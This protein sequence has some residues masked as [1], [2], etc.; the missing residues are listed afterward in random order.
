MTDPLFDVATNLDDETVATD[1]A[2]YW[3]WL[4][5]D[6]VSPQQF[7]IAT[8]YFNPGGFAQ[9]SDQ[10]EQAEHVRLLLG[11]EPDAVADLNRLR[12]LSR[13]HPTQTQAAELRRRLTEHHREIAQDRDLVGFSRHDDALIRRMIDWLK[14][15]KVEVHRLESRFLHGKAYLAGQGPGVMVG[16]SN[17]TRAGLTRNVELNLAR[18]EPTPVTQVAD[19]FDRLW[20]ESVDYDLA[21]LYEQRFAEHDPYVVYLRMLWERYGT[22]LDQPEPSPHELP[23]TRFQK[24]GLYRAMGILHRHRG[25]LVADG[26]GLGKTYLAGELVR[27]A[28]YDRRQRVLVIAPAALRDGP[29]RQ[30]LHEHRIGGVDV[31]SYEQ[32]SADPKMGG[33]GRGWMSFE[34]HE[35]AMVVIDEAHAYRN[36]VAERAQVLRKL[37]SGTPPKE[38]VLLTAT[39]VN[40]SLWDLYHLLS[41]FVRNDGA[42]LDAGIPSLREQFKDA[43]A[44]DP[45]T[46]SP[47][48]LFDVLDAVAV[49]RTRGFVKRFYPGETIRR[50]D[51]EIP[52]TFPQPE[53]IRVDYDF[54]AVLPGFF[55]Q[56][57]HALGVD[58]SDDDNP[59]PHPDEFV[60]DDTARLKLAR[61]APSAFLLEDDPE[62]YELQA[63]G[64]LRSGLLKR[65]ESS[66]F[67]FANTCATMAGSHDL[68]LEALSHGWVLTGDALAAFAKTD[69]D[70]FDPAV[71]AGGGTREP[72][73]RYDVDKLRAAVETDRDLLRH[74]H[75]QAASIDHTADPKLAALVDALA[76]IAAQA[77]A[78]GGPEQTERDRRKVLVFSYY[79]DTV[80]WI[81]RHLRWATIHDDR[82]GVYTDRW[83]TVTGSGDKQSALFGFAPIAAQAPTETADQFDILVTTDVLAEG[84]NLQQARHIV[85]FDLPWNP[86]R[87]VQRHGRIDRIGS[88]HSR[89]FLRSFFPSTKLN[90]L[91]GLERAIT[92][93]LTQAAKSIGVEGTVI[94]GSGVNTELIFGKTDEQVRRLHA[95]DVSVLEEAEAAASLSG[96]E[97]RRELVE[98]LDDPALRGQILGL[99]WVAGTGKATEGPAGFV[100]CARVA[101]HDRPLYRWVPLDADGNV[102]GGRI[103]ADTLTCLARARCEPDTARTLP[104]GMQDAAYDAW[105]AA[106][107]DIFD[108]WT[109]DTDPASL[110]V[111]IP[112]PMRD[113]AALLRAHG[114]PGKS[115]DTVHRLIDIIEAP[116]DKR[117]EREFRRALDTGGTDDERV[118][119]LVDA[120]DRLGLVEPPPQVQPLPEIELADVHLVCWVALVPGTSPSRAHD[121]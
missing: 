93:K 111:A 96:E 31:L 33:T 10:L 46:L 102:D 97:F 18:Y 29:W 88:P 42:F 11:A 4:L 38:L 17:F 37:L 109:A 76:A 52:I 90:E 101:D 103:D 19:W 120:V 25:V 41:L 107:N 24:D 79:A 71:I 60:Y 116:Y 14:S 8:A 7:A 13:L 64:L 55:D 23:L 115:L 80:E 89:V 54:D 108:R 72:A 74:F 110:A 77:H 51:V 21:G 61:Y 27:Q 81:A 34:P 43:E 40:N 95:S 36:P 47:E 48:V 62:A 75:A 114:V 58:P 112:K 44:S 5:D 99:P 50:G 104:T 6:R 113:A 85:N 20:N 49:R 121:A 83:D 26:V 30:F 22:E 15:G 59:L 119:N 91:L 2:G 1:L 39:P 67:A 35:Y 100:F 86:M 16:S 84:V 28:T 9:L 73:G 118:S 12:P 70:D 3:Q 53:L 56:F 94:P 66:P 117:T 92:R 78:E 69:S 98:A 65:F 32:L 82:I 106:C 105:E 45:D 68:F 57:A 87:L 63:A